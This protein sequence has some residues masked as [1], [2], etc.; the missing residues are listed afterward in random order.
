MSN[1]FFR[2]SNLT[3]CFHDDFRLPCLHVSLVK[4]VWFIESDDAQ[5]SYGSKNEQQNWQDER[6]FASPPLKLSINWRKRK[7]ENGLSKIKTRLDGSERK[8]KYTKVYFYSIDVSL[9]VNPSQLL[10]EICAHI[11]MVSKSFPLAPS[12]ILCLVK[13]FNNY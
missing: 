1:Y 6:R 10:H 9:S 13:C 7:S 12:L 5:F 8:Y 11:F 2:F 3:T 4:P